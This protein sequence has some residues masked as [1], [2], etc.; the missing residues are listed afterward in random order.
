MTAADLLPDEFG[1]LGL[2]KDIESA[3]DFTLLPMC[4]DL[5]KETSFK[6]LDLKVTRWAVYITIQQSTTNNA[7]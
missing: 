3:D 6:V 4:S 5:R 7:A 1:Q 2:G